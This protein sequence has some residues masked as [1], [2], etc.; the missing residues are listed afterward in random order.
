MTNCK[1]VRFEPCLI[2]KTPFSII[3]KSL[4]LPYLLTALLTPILRLFPVSDIYSMFVKFWKSRQRF[5]D[6]KR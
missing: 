5:L 6:C 4:E 1:K 2:H 3:Y